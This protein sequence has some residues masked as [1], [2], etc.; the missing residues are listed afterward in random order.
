MREE[1]K[2]AYCKLKYCTQC[3]YVWESYYCL[4]NRV[5]KTYKYKELCS[6][7]LNRQICAPCERERNGNN[8]SYRRA[9][10]LETQYC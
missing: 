9:K 10:K 6:Y 8:D 7:R 3:E 5:S 1:A 2:N 4:S